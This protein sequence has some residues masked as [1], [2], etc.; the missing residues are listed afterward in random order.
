MSFNRIGNSSLVI[1]P[2]KVTTSDQ[3]TCHLTVFFLSHRLVPQGRGL[4]VGH[5]HQS[6][7]Q[8]ATYLHTLKN[9]PNPLD[10]QP[11]PVSETESDHALVTINDEEQLLT[12]YN[13]QTGRVCSLSLTHSLTRSFT[14][15][16]MK[17]LRSGTVIGAQDS[18]LSRDKWLGAFLLWRT[19]LLCLL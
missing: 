3:V 11:K 7:F 13:S 15:S 16:R 9:N 1:V 2:G 8:S 6:R 14:R 4:L 5:N 19:H 12:I 17:S 18:S 10:T